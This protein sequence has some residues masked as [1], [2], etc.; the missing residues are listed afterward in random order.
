M[1]GGE[2]DGGS[3]Q[4]LTGLT[5]LKS[6]TLSL[7]TLND[8][9]VKA[10]R[11][12]LVARVIREVESDLDQPTADEA[13]L[14]DENAYNATLRSGWVDLPELVAGTPYLIDQ[15]LMLAMLDLQ[16]ELRRRLGPNNHTIVEG[17]R[18]DA[19]CHGDIVQDRLLFRFGVAEQAIARAG[20]G[21]SSHPTVDVLNRFALQVACLSDRQLAELE[22]AMTQGFEMVSQR[23]R[24][25][26]LQA[27]IPAFARLVAPLQ[28]LVFDARKHRGAF[29]QSYHWFRQ[30]RSDLRA[31]VASSGWATGDVLAWDRRVGALV[32]YPRCSSAVTSK[33]IDFNVLLDSLSDPRAIGFGGCGLSFMLSAGPKTFPRT[34]PV[35]TTDPRNS[36]GQRY[37]CPTMDCGTNGLPSGSMSQATKGGFVA[38]WTTPS[39]ADAAPLTT[40]CVGAAGDPDGTV[41]GLDQCIDAEFRSLLAAQKQN[42][43]FENF[44]SCLLDGMGAGQLPAAGTSPWLTGVPAGANCDLSDNGTGS[45]STAATAPTTGTPPRPVPGTPPG[46]GDA[47]KFKNTDGSYTYVYQTQ[48]GRIFMAVSGN[49]VAVL[50]PDGEVWYEAGSCINCTDI[51]KNYFATGLI[52]MQVKGAEG[53][54]AQSMA[55]TALNAMAL[56]DTNGWLWNRGGMISEWVPGSSPGAKGCV[57]PLAC[58]DECTGMGRQIGALQACTKDL[59][60]ALAAATGRPTPEIQRDLGRVSFPHPTDFSVPDSAIGACM[61]SPSAPRPA[62]A[63][64]LIMCADGF[65]NEVAGSCRCSSTAIF[66]LPQLCPEV[67]CPND[68]APNSST[69]ICDPPEPVSGTLPDGGPIP[70]P[71]GWQTDIDASLRGCVARDVAKGRQT[72]DVALDPRRISGANGVSWWRVSQD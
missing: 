69:C 64:G 49:V 70:D 22:Q 61:S 32:G 33:C 25:Q 4:A 16:G 66:T 35:G 6:S 34:G 46:K 71:A 62:L 17:L 37:V 14:L 65:S 68:Q 23:L 45:S 18:D 3:Q 36:A 52:A 8:R 50:G 72:Y 27:I 58:A 5:R 48:D 12:Q 43:P 19:G 28:L 13:Y 56:R 51:E 60:G 1:G 40:Y 26:N 30:H 44:T 9:D 47:V 54:A 10:T 31:I 57:D 11:K 24:F 21:T 63:C 42:S 39:L 55:E 38:L 7:N 67:R 59:L 15:P 29:S 41:F 53:D 20:L 2:P